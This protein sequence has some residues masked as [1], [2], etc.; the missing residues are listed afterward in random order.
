MEDNFYDKYFYYKKAKMAVIK[1]GTKLQGNRKL[2]KNELVDKNL[3]ESSN[4]I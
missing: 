3:D 1:P 4:F 2:I